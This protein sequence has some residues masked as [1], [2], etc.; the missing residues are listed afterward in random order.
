M[1]AKDWAEG[2][3]KGIL[4]VQSFGYSRQI[5]P[6]HLLV[7]IVPTVNSTMVYLKFC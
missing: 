2:G 4:R 1:V 5:D 3:G 6:R 7:S